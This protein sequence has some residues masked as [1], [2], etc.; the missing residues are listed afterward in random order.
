[1]PINVRSLPSSCPSLYPAVCACAPIRTDRRTY[2]HRKA[3]VHACMP[4]LTHARTHACTRAHAHVLAHACTNG[5]TDR[6]THTHTHTHNRPH[7]HMLAYSDGCTLSRTESCTDT[8]RK[9]LRTKARTE[10]R[11]HAPTHARTLAACTRTRMHACTYTRTHSIAGID[12]FQG[13]LRGRCFFTEAHEVP[14]PLT[15]PDPH[16]RT[17]AHPSACRCSYF[18]TGRRLRRSGLQI[19]PPMRTF[20]FVSHTCRIYIEYHYSYIM[21]HVVTF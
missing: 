5:Q 4:A 9:H 11:T 1:M 20:C 12:I 7:A 15:P 8:R 17:Y 18:Q 2:V 13:K 10:A 6:H 16:A 19:R 3:H 21:R 14:R